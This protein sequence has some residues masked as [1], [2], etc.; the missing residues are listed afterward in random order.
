V[1]ISILAARFKKTRLIGFGLFWFLI[2]LLPTS[3]FPLAEVMNDHRT[4]LP[5]IGLV[6]AMADAASLL[7]ARLDR[8]WVKV[9]AACAV[10]LFLCAEAFATFQRNKVWRTEET[11]WRDV[12]IK[13]PRNPRGLMNYGTTLMAK[14][15][16]LIAHARAE[17][18]RVLLR[19]ALELSPTDLTARDR[20]PRKNVAL[21][22][23]QKPGSRSSSLL[24]APKLPKP[25]S[26]FS[27]QPS[28]TGIRARPTLALAGN[29]LIGCT[30]HY[31]I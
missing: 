21:P 5:Y 14:G 10:G 18:A 22:A 27:L 26:T 1:T 20:N 17:E 25:T 16:Y 15:K 30:S 8:P 31:C 24:P 29:L 7:A 6:I 9:S 12:T 13:S 19:S 28:V 11:L 23:L 4:F 2:A 3:L